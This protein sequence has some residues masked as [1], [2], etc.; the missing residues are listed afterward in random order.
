M[1]AVLVSLTTVAGSAMAQK[2]DTAKVG[3]LTI[4]SATLPIVTSIVFPAPY[5]VE[6]RGSGTVG[7]Q[8]ATDTIALSAPAPCVQG[9]GTYVNGQPAGGMLVKA[10][11]SN[12]GVARVPPQ[13]IFV[14]VG[15]TTQT[16]TVLTTGV[17]SCN[18]QGGEGTL[19]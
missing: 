6:I 8:E 14:P 19:H 1:I 17:W 15:K 4:A 11:S 2:T 5:I 3:T 12:P 16:F 13:G 10:S 9:C 18:V 7:G